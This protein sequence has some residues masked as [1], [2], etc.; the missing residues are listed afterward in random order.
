M[1]TKLI[2]TEIS[3]DGRFAKLKKPLEFSIVYTDFV[4]AENDYLNINIVDDTYADL[5]FDIAFELFFLYDHY[6][7]EDDLNLTGNAI[8]LKN[9]ILEYL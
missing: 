9:R 7:L 5:E 2:I 6:G 1:I 8:E 3:A 4:I